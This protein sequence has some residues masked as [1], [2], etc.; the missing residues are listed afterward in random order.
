MAL[1][2]EVHSPEF[3]NYG[4]PIRTSDWLMKSVS[5]IYSLAHGPL[6]L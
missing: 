6:K 5:P 4:P 2:D 3:D 1:I